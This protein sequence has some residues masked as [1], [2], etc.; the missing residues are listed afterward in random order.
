MEERYVVLFYIL[1][2]SY[3]YDIMCAG[4]PVDVTPR[5]DDK[6]LGKDTSQNDNFRYDPFSQDR[7]PF[8]AHTRKTNPRSDLPNTEPHRI[9]RRGIPYGP[10]VTKAERKAGKTELNRGLLFKAYQ[11]NISNGFQFIQS[12]ESPPLYQNLYWLLNRIA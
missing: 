11:S 10:E 9:L 4:A 12:S 8:V 7:C 1:F 2:M 3:R 5:Q 6:E